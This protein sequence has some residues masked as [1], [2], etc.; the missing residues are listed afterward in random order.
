M[1]TII[2]DSSTIISLATNDLLWILKDLKK[3]FDGRFVIPESVK[4]ELVDNPFNSKYYKLEAIMINNYINKGYLE[5]YKA[6]DV[7]NLLDISNKI[8]YADDKNLVILHKA[9]IEALAL[10]SKINADAYSVD[11]RTM[12]LMIENPFRLRKLLERK[13]ERKISINKENLKKF[14]S[15][16][17]KI[18]IIRSTELALIA[19]EKGLFKDLINDNVKEKDLVEAL[20]WGL[21][22]RGCSISDKEIEEIGRSEL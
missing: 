6:I 8:C 17:V 20:L 16:T 11:E 3:Y 5:V 10:A 21:K 19:Y 12:R 1:K 18:P 7:E 2:F 14:E 22:M 4:I 9:E 15:M 13:L